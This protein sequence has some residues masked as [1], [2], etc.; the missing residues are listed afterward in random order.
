MSMFGSDHRA[1]ISALNRQVRELQE[2]LA[3]VETAVMPIRVGELDPSSWGLLCY[4]G[5]TDTR[6]AISQDRAIRMLFDHLGLSLT[7]IPG[8][9]EK[10]VLEKKGKAK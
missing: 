3:K 2:R 9:P 8:T 4:P 6:A 10:I 7:R 1:E 5:W